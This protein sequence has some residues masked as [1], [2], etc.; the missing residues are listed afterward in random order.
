MRISIF[1][2]KLVMNIYYTLLRYIEAQE[3]NQEYEIQDIFAPVVLKNLAFGD[4]LSA[5]LRSRCAR[6]HGC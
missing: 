3:S 1:D 5:F 4:C 6:T 2:P